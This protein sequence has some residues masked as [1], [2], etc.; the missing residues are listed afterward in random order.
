VVRGPRAI[1]ADLKRLAEAVED[2]LKGFG[3]ADLHFGASALTGQRSVEA[4]YGSDRPQAPVRAMQQ[5][6]YG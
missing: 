3:F 2:G 6:F 4:I 1:A 5:A